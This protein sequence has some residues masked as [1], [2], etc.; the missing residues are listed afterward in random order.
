MQK[1]E[2]RATTSTISAEYPE[3]QVGLTAKDL[4]RIELVNRFIL[5]NTKNVRKSVDERQQVVEWRPIH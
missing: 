4:K 2:D 3:I 1:T 5:R